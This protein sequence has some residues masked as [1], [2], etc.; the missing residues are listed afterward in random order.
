TELKPGDYVAISASRYPFASVLPSVKR[1]R[2]WIRSISSTL[3][4]NARQAQKPYDAERRLD[5]EYE[6]QRRSSE[7]S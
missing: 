2:E 5:E 4:W 1:S 7:S 6:Q 3:N